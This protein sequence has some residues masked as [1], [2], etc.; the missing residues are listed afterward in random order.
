[1]EDAVWKSLA[2]R[3]S[4]ALMLSELGP[5]ERQCEAQVDKSGMKGKYH[6]AVVESLP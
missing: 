4:L 5:G 2:L 3:G 1:M 6:A